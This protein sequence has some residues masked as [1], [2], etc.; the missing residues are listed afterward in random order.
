VIFC[1]LTPAAAAVAMMSRLLP[2]LVLLAVIGV[3]T[4]EAQVP[5]YNSK[6][7]RIEQIDEG[8]W[9]FTGQVELENEEI[10]GQKFYANV[11]DLFT[12][13]NRVEASGNVV[14][15]TA[16]ARIAAERAVFFTRAGTGTFYNASGLAS[17]GERADKSMF[18]ALEPDVYFYGE[19]LEKTG[20]D[21]YKIAKGGFT[22]CVQP[23]PRWELVTGSASINV[24]EYAV[25][26][27]AVM[28][29][30]DVPIF[31][32]P[33]M[34]Y[35]IQD[36]DRATGFLLPTYGR[37]N[38]Q[39]QSVSN[40]FFWAISR[41]QDLTVMHDW[42]TATGQGYGTEY[43]WMRSAAS[44]GNLRAYR[45]QQKAAN[46][47]G[48][49]LPES[50]SL[51]LNGSVTQDLPFR[52]KGR[53]RIDYSS[54]I[55]ANQ[56]YSQDVFN[57]TNGLSSWNGNISGSWQFLNTSL[58]AQRTQQFFSATASRI[59]GSLPSLTAAVSNRR[60]GPL[61]IYFALQSEAS[62][63]LYIERNGDDELDR[64]MGRF[65]VIPTLRM[66]ISGLTFININLNAAYRT[67]WYSQSLDQDGE[68]VDDDYT[69]RY[70]DLRAEVLGP[71]FSRVYTP[72]NFLAD[73]L[74]HVIEPS[75]TLQRIT[76]IDGEGKVA[77]LGSSY[78]RVVGGV[79]R[80]T[81]G[82]TNRIL[83][84]K[85]PKEASASP[86]ASAPRDLLTASISQSYYTDQRASQF[87]SAY[88]SSYIDLGGGRPPSNYS[89]VSLNVRS[90]LSTQ[91]G[92]TY[93][94][95]YDA[96][97]SKV[98]SMSTGGD[99]GAPNRQVSL[100]WS[101]S[102]SSFFPTNTLNGSTRLVFMGGRLGTN[103][104]MYW[105]IEQDRLVQQRMTAFF[106]AQCCGI[107]FEYQELGVG[108]FATASPLKIR[109]FNMGFTLAGLG[110][111]SNFF[112]NFGGSSY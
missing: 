96:A 39:G 68:Q 69:R 110:T 30:K 41:S 62:R 83:V 56:L 11:V 28:R 27:N 99:Y 1:G 45:L 111:F 75:F 13:D 15:E 25:L 37:S 81:Y 91:I 50:R 97:E 65:D 9:R 38:I 71:V 8:H 36:D 47:N 26:R 7:F 87:D 12:A 78:D 59:S 89:P 40:A 80:I 95:E 77:T 29:V 32:L 52:L 70:A 58:T 16:T 106:N 49:D 51:L 103:Y 86:L 48:F 84:R 108:S 33:I 44:V 5:G 100:A 66:P 6:Q 92:A 34:Y 43:R 46:V 3:A 98:L 109:R 85:A 2:C 31:Y 17:L 4:A 22:T 42:F 82:L 57:A 105:D 63:P 54:N 88:Q 101:R 55:T 76:A 107:V 18:G 64:S 53:A 73:R 67:T 61:P 10:K 19:V 20:E 74:K 102:L 35:P 90:Q 79:T 14:Y 112:G 23:T 60:I 104:S 72:N 21:R 24:G 94:M 93:R